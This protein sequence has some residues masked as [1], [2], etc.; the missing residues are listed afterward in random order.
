MINQS[1]LEKHVTWPTVAKGLLGGVSGP[2]P[3][4]LP[5]LWP[6]SAIFPTLFMTWTKIWNP[7]YD[8]TLNIK[9]QFRPM[10]NYHKHSLWRTFVDF[11][12]AEWWKTGFF[13]NIYRHIKARVQKP[14]PIY[15]QNGRNRLKLIPYLWPKRPKNHTLWG[16]TYL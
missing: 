7:I 14:Y 11:L 9:T 8:L 3:K 6:R 13:W 16:R 12:F 1:V 4:P 15:N 2:H 10:L 5:Y